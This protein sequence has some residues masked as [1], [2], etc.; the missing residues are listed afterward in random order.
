M[1]ITGLANNPFTLLSKQA[2]VKIWEVN[3][4]R[5]ELL[6]EYGGIADKDIDSR[7]EQQFNMALDKLAEWRLTK[8]SD[9]SL[10]GEEL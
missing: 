4:E 1:F 5:C 6:T 2:G 7:V 10:G 3:E 9:C 8:P